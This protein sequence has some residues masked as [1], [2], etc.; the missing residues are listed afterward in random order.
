MHHC[1]TNLVVQT[2]NTHSLAIKMSSFGTF[3]PA[4]ERTE[5]NPLVAQATNRTNTGPIIGGLAGNG[6]Y[7]FSLVQQIAAKTPRFR[8]H[9]SPKDIDN[10]KENRGKFLKLITLTDFSPMTKEAMEDWLDA[11]A[12][13]VTR[14][15]LTCDLFQDA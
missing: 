10:Q 14:N 5:E 8:V 2:N 3:E 4:M 11:V 15:R 1:F 6:P 7:G 12:R 13:Q 9:L